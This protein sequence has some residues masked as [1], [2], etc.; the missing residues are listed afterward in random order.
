MTNC[1]PG[2]LALVIRDDP[3]KPL[4]GKLVWVL[5]PYDLKNDL[6]NGFPILA[7]VLDRRDVVIWWIAS[8]S[9]GLIP[10]AVQT[11]EGKKTTWH[12]EGPWLDAW[13]RPIRD[14]PGEDEMLQAMRERKST[15]PLVHV[16]DA[17]KEALREK[18]KEP[19]IPFF[20]QP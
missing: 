2:D 11:P 3:T 17:L 8:A 5:R 15:Q 1:K 19:K 7:Q 20:T 4:A 16:Y 18:L 12:E 9:S 14:Q 6:L 13:L 10:N